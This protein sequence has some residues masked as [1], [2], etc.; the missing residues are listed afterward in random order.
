MRVSAFRGYHVKPADAAE[1]SV[2]EPSSFSRKTGKEYL[3]AHPQSLLGALRPDLISG[4]KKRGDLQSLSAKAGDELEK[5]L[6]AGD[7][8]ADAEFGIYLYRQVHDAHVQIGIAVTCHL[9]DWRDE[10]ILPHEAIIPERVEEV[11]ALL[12]GLNA[13]PF[14][15]Q[16]GFE[17][18]DSL[19][20]LIDDWIDLNPPT[21]EF[22]D[23]QG[24]T[25]ALWRI[26]GENADPFLDEMELIDRAYII[27]GHHRVAAADEISKDQKSEGSEEEDLAPCHWVAACF[28]S[29]DQLELETHARVIR[30]FGRLSADGFL[31]AISKVLPLDSNR[32]SRPED[33]F[34]ACIYAGDGWHTVRWGAPESDDPLDSID[35]RLLELFILEPILDIHE[36]NRAERLSYLPGGTD[37]GKLEKLVDSGEAAA[38]IRLH[39]PEI[40]DVIALAD[41]A[42]SM[43]AKTTCFEP[44][45]RTGLFMHR[46]ELD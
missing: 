16:L 5:R 26:D 35:A 3:K 41:M 19:D 31:H 10:K 14:P 38:V 6:E 36:G 46:L 40:G 8:L 29:F 15:V 23:A 4:R 45:L 2:N 17:G 42:E 11:K 39:P 27:D 13:H 21:T 37:T 30:D 22:E 43:P 20:D 1:I 9:D 25:H 7:L 34:E 12:T 33:R 24:K 18:R 32:Q 44:K 28:F